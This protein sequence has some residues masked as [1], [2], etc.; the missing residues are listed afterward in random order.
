[1]NPM[2]TGQSVFTEE[3]RENAR[4]WSNTDFASGLPT[5]LSVQPGGSSA[6]NSV[7]FLGERLIFWIEF[8]SVD[9]AKTRPFRAGMKRRPLR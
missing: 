9:G 5:T 3:G 2:I 6:R 8:I 7:I 1:M 4:R